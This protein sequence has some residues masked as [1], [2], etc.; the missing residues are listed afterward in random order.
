MDWAAL[1]LTFIWI[2][3]FS[4]LRLKSAYFLDFIRLNWFLKS[5]YFF[6][7][8]HHSI[9]VTNLK[10]SPIFDLEIFRK[11][12]IFAKFL[13]IAFFFSFRT[14]PFII[15]I[16]HVKYYI[17][18]FAKIL[19]SKNFLCKNWGKISDLLLKNGWPGVKKKALCFL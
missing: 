8:S 5:P 2:A 7:G 1:P 14:I 18:I 3:N 13:Y 4:N 9:H 12:K 10:F 17:K 19:Y 6:E 16:F 15:F 11:Y